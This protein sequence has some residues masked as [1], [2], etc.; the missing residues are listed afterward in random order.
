MPPGSSAV[1][2]HA[3]TLGVGTAVAL[4][5]LAG[6]LA[7]AIAAPERM[8]CP[9]TSYAAATRAYRDSMW[10][11]RARLS[12]ADDHWGAAGQSWTLIHTQIVHTFKGRPPPRLDILTHGDDSGPWLD[13]SS[14]S[15][16]GEDYLLFLRPA[17]PGSPIEGVATVSDGC[18]ASKPWSRVSHEEIR[19]LASPPGR[20]TLAQ[21]VRSEGPVRHVHA[22]AAEHK[23]RRGWHWRWPAPLRALFA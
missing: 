10:V 5:G 20:L 19:S 7:P 17:P 23:G 16:L 18:G 8:E 22:T 13:G 15:N 2:I 4:L 9:R 12:A 6:V 21:E 1:S 14:L 3:P 11:V